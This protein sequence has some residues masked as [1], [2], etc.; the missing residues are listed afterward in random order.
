MVANA[1]VPITLPVMPSMSEVETMKEMCKVAAYSGFLNSSAPMTNQTQRA[2]DAFFVM[3]YGR[4]LGIPPMT[5]LKTIYVIEGKPS[6][7]GQALLGLLRKGGCE[8][9]VPDPG[10][11]TDRAVVRIRRP[12]SDAWKTYTY[13]MEMATKA[14][15]AGRAIWGKYPREMLIWRAVSTAA[16]MEASDIA[17]GLYT[18]EELSDTEVDENGEPIGKIVITKSDGKPIDEPSVSAPQDDIE[19]G[20]IIDFPQ[21][22]A[23]ESPKSDEPVNWY[24][25][26]KTAAD[27]AFAQRNLTYASAC[28]LTGEQIAIYFSS[29]DAAL[30][31]IDSKIKPPAPKTNGAPPPA[32]KPQPAVSWTDESYQAFLKTLADEYD[33]PADELLKLVGMSDWRAAYPSPEAALKNV[34]NTARARQLPLICRSVAIKAGKNNGART[35]LITP[36]QVFAFFGGRH[37]L[38]KFM[39]EEEGGAFWTTNNLGAWK[40]GAQYPTTPF[41]VVW[42][43]E[44]GE[45]KINALVSL[46]AQPAPEPVADDE[47]TA[48]IPF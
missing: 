22:P 16:R 19:E 29:L 33:L 27:A 17:G 39:G 25:L 2:A 28:E 45:M 18:I 3:M 32:Q 21:Q 7:S 1:I 37:E 4:E 14:G 48:D 5:A 30:K 40:L 8:V 36:T 10:T 9:D 41:K 38:L 12:G 20:K 46:A 11:V 35:E 15:L 23:P 34:R 43:T 44:K 6:C 47:Q 31:V 24:T 42:T 13:T 26:D